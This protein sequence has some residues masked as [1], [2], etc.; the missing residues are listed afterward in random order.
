VVAPGG[1]VGADVLQGGQY[2]QRVVSGRNL[3]R[4]PGSVAVLGWLA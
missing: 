3:A 2:C 4:A 1:V